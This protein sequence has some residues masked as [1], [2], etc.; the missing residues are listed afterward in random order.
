MFHSSRVKF[1]FC[2]CI[3]ELVFGVDVFDLNLGV[4]I[5]FV[6]Q[7]IKSNSLGSGHT[8][9]RRTSAFDDH[10]NHCFVVVKNVEHRTEKTS[11]STKH[12]QHYSTQ[13]CCAW[14]A[15]QFGFGYA[16]LMWYHATSF[17][18]LDL[19][20]SLIEFGKVKDFYNQI[21][22]IKSWYSIRA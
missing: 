3:C 20:L 2:Q 1:P 4:Q 15:L 8:S 17:I 21:P 12:N 9:H 10:F 7:P 19:W 6:K 14:L 11:R 16:C 13:D 5:I 22:K 18:V